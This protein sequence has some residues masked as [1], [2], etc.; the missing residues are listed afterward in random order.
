MRCEADA[1]G[2]TSQQAGAGEFVDG[3]LGGGEKIGAEVMAEL[4]EI[5]AAVE[6]KAE[7]EGL[8][9]GVFFVDV[10]NGL[11]G[12]GAELREELRAGVQVG[13]EVVWVCESYRCPRLRLKHG[14][15]VEAEAE[16]GVAMPIL[17][18]VA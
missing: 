8:L 10:V 14:V 9:E 13:V 1:A 16:V 3:G 15:R 4:R 7:E 18:V 12:C 17:E 2:F 5:D 11:G 6:A